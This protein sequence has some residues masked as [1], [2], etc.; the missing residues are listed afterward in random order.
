VLF[1]AFLRKATELSVLKDLI[2]TLL[3]TEFKNIP[4]DIA[5]G[6]SHQ[7]GSSH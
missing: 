2:I 5:P 1:S 4:T 3:G 7:N 6:I